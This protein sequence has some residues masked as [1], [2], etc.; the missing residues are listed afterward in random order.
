ML[1]NPGALK[2]LFL[3]FLECLHLIDSTAR[4]TQ[5]GLQKRGARDLFG[6]VFKT[7]AE[8]RT[9]ATAA[10]TDMLTSDAESGLRREIDCLVRVFRLFK[11]GA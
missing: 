5:E 1:A 8:K 4:G 3:K 6:G 2:S 9:P 11:E 10:Q 7:A